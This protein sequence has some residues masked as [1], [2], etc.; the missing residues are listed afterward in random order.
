MADQQE[1]PNPANPMWGHVRTTLVMD[2]KS[3]LFEVKAPAGAKVVG[4]WHE[5]RHSQIALATGSTAEQDVLVVMWFGDLHAEFV[6]RELVVMPQGGRVQLTPP[7]T[8]AH[9]CSFP[10]PSMEGPIVLS[11][12]EVEHNVEN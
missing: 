11:I 4:A 6:S 10:V 7:A 5:K 3:T 9:L 2:G 8:L 1:A 12:C